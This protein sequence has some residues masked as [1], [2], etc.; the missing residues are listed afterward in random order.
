[1][2]LQRNEL[3]VIA[4]IIAYIAFFTHPPPSHISNLL[5]S[6]VG[7]MII[8]LGI[9]YVIAYQSLIVGIFLGIAYIMTATRL[10]EFFVDRTDPRPP[11]E[12]VERG[13]PKIGED[14]R[15]M[16]KIND[17]R[18]SKGKTSL[19]ASEFGEYESSAVSTSQ[20]KALKCKQL[21]AAGL[22]CDDLTKEVPKSNGVPKP[23]TVGIVGAATKANGG[24]RL[25]QKQGKNTVP[26][27]QTTTMPKPFPPTTKEGFGNF[28]AF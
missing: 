9:L 25:P 16:T 28:A 23:T 17:E 10:T 5:E 13:A 11:P 3:I 8:L 12:I 7:H 26:T 19:S 14:T 18:L 22:P 15:S 20:E 4:I 1:M 2:K 27:K 21:R 6:P 24:D